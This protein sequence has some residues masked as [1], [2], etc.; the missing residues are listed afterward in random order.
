MT[1]EQQTMA[2]HTETVTIHVN[3][4][5]VE[6]TQRHVT[7]LTIKQAAITQRVPIQLD[8]VL[9]EE[10]GDHRTRTIGDQEHVTV[11]THSRFLAIP[12]D[13]NS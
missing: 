8:F 7:G 6:L 4:L 12:N 9:S 10:L 3:E 11:T 5:P 13:D 1:S 2:A